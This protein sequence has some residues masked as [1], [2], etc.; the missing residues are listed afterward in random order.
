MCNLDLKIME[1]TKKCQHCGQE[2]KAAAKKCHFCGQWQ[3]E[4]SDSQQKQAESQ[5]AADSQTDFSSTK[6]KGSGKWAIPVIGILGLILAFLVVQ[7]LPIS[8]SKAKSPK[9]EYLPFQETKDGNWGLISTDGEVL[10]SEEFNQRPT[11]V[12]NGRFMVKNAD[13]LWEIYTAEKKPKKIGGEYLQVGYFYENVAPAVERGGPIQLIDRNGKV[14]VT[15][16]KIDGKEV[17]SCT[18]FI[19]GKMTVKVGDYWGT[20]DTNGKIVIE[21]KYVFLDASCNGYYIALEKKYASVDESQKAYTILNGKGKEVG[22]IK[23]SKFS[24]LHQVITSI[25]SIP[26]KDYIVDNSVVVKTERGVGLIG[27]DGEWKIKPM[28]KVKTITQKQGRYYSF[29]GDG[30]GLLND[31]GEIVIRP[32]Y[33]LVYMI[34]DDIFSATKSGSDNLALYNLNDERI[35]DD[36]YKD[37]RPFYD[38][39]FA[40]AQVGEHDYVLINKKGEEQKLKV[41]IYDIDGKNPDSQLTSDYVDLDNLVKLLHISKE[42]MMDLTL[43][44]DALKAIETINGMEGI[45]TRISEDAKKNS[46]NDIAD[47]QIYKGKTSINLGIDIQGLIVKKQEGSGWFSYTTYDWSKNPISSYR[48]SIDLGL[49]SRLKGRMSQFY[50][51]VEAAVKKCGKVVK[52]GKNAVV[53]DAGNDNFYYAVWAGKSVTVFYGKYNPDLCDVE[54]YDDADENSNIVAIPPGVVLKSSSGQSSAQESDEEE[55]YGDLGSP[56]NEV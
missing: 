45:L 50:K 8:C 3:T 51:K 23:A 31:E 40:F 42:S 4:E 6:K 5:P 33:D 48:L 27:F 49:N 24:E 15:L 17:E 9:I 2:I 16:D 47:A 21:P 29:Y 44:M 53:V 19:H 37:I 22:K 34:D 55:D 14:K 54:L 39:K 18:N 43:N 32:K 41:D 20:V 7:L 26:F 13:N 11:V 36:D 52:Q 10:F 12:I 38:G 56:P 28:S 30:F 46:T 35:G 1:E 25:T